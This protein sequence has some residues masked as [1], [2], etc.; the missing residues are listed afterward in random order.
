[1]TTTKKKK[2]T[3]KTSAKKELDA[4]KGAV[5]SA[6]DLIDDKTLD[7]VSKPSV[8]SQVIQSLGKVQAEISAIGK[9][10][11]NEQQRYSFRGIEDVLNTLSPLLIKHNLIC[12]PHMIDHH[13]EKSGKAVQVTVN[14]RYEWV[15]TLDT[16]TTSINTVGEALDYSDKGTGKAMSMAYKQMCF[17]LFCIPTEQ[18]DADDEYIERDTPQASQQVSQDKV[19]SDK[20]DKEKW[21]ALYERVQPF[22]PKDKPATALVKFMR[23][24]KFTVPKDMK[25]LT[26]ERARNVLKKIKEVKEEQA[27]EEQE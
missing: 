10:R 17:Q 15:S 12:L 5:K 8:A 11:R 7:E 25:R 23:K 4:S 19:S 24:Y 20:M 2:T 6:Q 16:S 9:N 26:V 18:K 27:N 14:M 3:K 1:M 13:I 21:D 22:Y